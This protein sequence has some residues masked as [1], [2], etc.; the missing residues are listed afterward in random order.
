MIREQ[1]NRALRSEENDKEKDGEHIKGNGALTY[2]PNFKN[3]SFLTRIARTCN[4][5]M[6]TQELRDFLRQHLLS[7]CE[8]LGTQKAS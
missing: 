1:V 3:L 5:Y 6:H 2:N 8:V 7:F 4:F